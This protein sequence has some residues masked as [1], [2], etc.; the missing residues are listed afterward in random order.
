MARGFEFQRE[1]EDERRR[2][3]ESEEVRRVKKAN[4][5]RRWKSWLENSKRKVEK[6]VVNFKNQTKL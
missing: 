6:I 5:V 4:G 3:R 2:P 1:I